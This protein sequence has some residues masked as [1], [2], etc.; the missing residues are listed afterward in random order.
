MDTIN[1]NPAIEDGDF[2]RA[3]KAA[4]SEHDVQGVIVDGRGNPGGYHFHRDLFEFLAQYT[5]EDNLFYLMDGRTYSAA[6][7][8][9]AHLYSLGAI[10]VGEP[11]GQAT[12]IYYNIGDVTNPWEIQLNYSGYWLYVPTGFIT[13]SAYGVTPEDRVFRPHVHID[14]TIEDWMDNRDPLYIH[15]LELLNK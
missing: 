4:F 13:M 8:A 7:E 3:I 12:E 10:V 2:Y 14:Y 5:P 6:L 15:I 9:G 11:S 1:G